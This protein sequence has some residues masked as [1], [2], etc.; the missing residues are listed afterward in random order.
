M[1]KKNG[2]GHWQPD[3]GGILKVLF[4]AG[5]LIATYFY[6]I[7]NLK[8]TQAVQQVEIEKLCLDSLRD[9]V[10]RKAEYRE[11]SDKIDDLKTLIIQLKD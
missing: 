8:T 2:Q 7:G 11:L 1:I 10:E 4:I 5:S 9:R 6:S 3:I